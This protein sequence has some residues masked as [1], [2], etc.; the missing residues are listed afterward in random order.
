MAFEEAR[1]ARDEHEELPVAEALRDACAHDGTLQRIMR[2]LERAT[3]RHEAALAQCRDAHNVAA[4]GRELSRYRSELQP[5]LREALVT[6]RAHFYD[7][8]DDEG[9]AFMRR[10]TSCAQVEEDLLRDLPVPKAS[11]VRTGTVG[12]WFASFAHEAVQTLPEA[13]LA[14]TEATEEAAL[15]RL[16]RAERQMLRQVAATDTDTV[17]SEGVLAQ[18]SALASSIDGMSLEIASDTVGVDVKSGEAAKVLREQQERRRSRLQKLRR[19]RQKRQQEQESQEN[20]KQQLQQLQH[21]QERAAKEQ[22]QIAEAAKREVARVSTLQQ[23]QQ[24]DLQALTA[25]TL[26]QAR[27]RRLEEEQRAKSA[28]EECAVLKTKLVE[29]QLRAGDVD[30]GGIEREKRDSE[31]E[32]EEK[33]EQ[34]EAEAESKHEVSQ[35]LAQQHARERDAS[36]RRGNAELQLQLLRAQLEQVQSTEELQREERR[37]LSSEQVSQMRRLLQ[38]RLVTS[39]EG[40]ADVCRVA[41]ECAAATLRG[42]RQRR[43]RQLLQAHEEQRKLL[44][45]VGASVD[46]AHALEQAQQAQLQEALD[47]H[48]E[49]IHAVLPDLHD[50]L[51][52]VEQ[53]VVRQHYLAWE[54]ANIAVSINTTASTR[55]ATELVTP[56]GAASAVGSRKQQKEA[57]PSE[58]KP[59]TALYSLAI[60]KKMGSIE[61]L[62]RDVVTARQLKQQRSAQ[63][64]ADTLAEAVDAHLSLVQRHTQR[65]P[66]LARHDDAVV[67]LPW[68]DEQVSFARAVFNELKRACVDVC[69]VRVVRTFPGLTSSDSRG[70]AECPLTA[71][72]ALHRR[73]RTLYVH[74]RLLESPQAVVVA[75]A[76]VKA[77]CK[78]SPVSLDLIDTRRTR[79][80]GRHKSDAGDG[81]G[82]TEHSARSM[83]LLFAEQPRV[84]YRFVSELVES[85][86]TLMLHRM[87]QQARPLPHGHRRRTHTAQE[88]ARENAH[89][90]R[91]ADTLRALCDASLFAHAS[92]LQQLLLAELN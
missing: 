30:I 76:L 78:A 51:R 67:A 6:L 66:N 62:L 41:V 27:Q 55:A 83:K 52:S 71:L 72:V 17:R 32:E 79:R 87:Q 2:K 45:S 48:I 23:Q 74:R 65:D 88:E 35:N 90:Q 1:Q 81:D 15:R 77:M 22:Q 57:P 53:A 34:E 28:E 46:N 4:L 47:A 82:S 63:Q 89:K 49:L 42:Q 80:D 54:R 75:A 10:V 7:D 68:R 73:T 12:A 18:V 69:E 31:H 84:L 85:G 36:R 9:V 8:S 29:L 20:R 13:A 56:T 14:E 70:D 38:L 44:R 91:R 37:A 25:A 58:Q 61:Q 26:A 11:H 33:E 21:E 5:A 19:E 50:D 40:K 3:T 92:P 16:E 86:T 24:A 43:L 60:Y 64:S 39:E 59:E